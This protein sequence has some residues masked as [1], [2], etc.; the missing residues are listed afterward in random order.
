MGFGGVPD[1]R[2]DFSVFCHLEIDQV[3]GQ[4]AVFDRNVAIHFD[5]HIFGPC[6]HIGR[7]AAWTAVFFP[8]K[9]VVARQRQRLD[10]CGRTKFQFTWHRVRFDDFICQLQQ[11]Q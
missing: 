5:Y 2:M 1:V 10:Q 11:I 6:C 7:R 3:V 8:A 9:L 4:S